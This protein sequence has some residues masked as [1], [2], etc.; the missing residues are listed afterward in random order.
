MRQQHRVAMHERRHAAD[1]EAHVRRD[2]GQRAEQR[3]RFEPRFGE[4][5]V[6]DPHRVE[7]AR[8]LGGRGEVDEIADADGA[9][10]DSAVRKDETDRGRGHAAPPVEWS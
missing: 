1:A 2:A 5:T 9:Q 7:R 3:H 4:E 6:A 10:D 8:C